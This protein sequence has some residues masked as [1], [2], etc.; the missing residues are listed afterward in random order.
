MLKKIVVY[1]FLTVL[2]TFHARA[3]TPVYD[4]AV[5]LGFDCQVAWQLEANNMRKF[6]YPFDWVHTHF[7]SLINFIVNKGANFLDADKIAVIGPYP[8]DPSRLHV[9]DVVYG[10]ISYHDFRANPPFENY[11]EV[12]AKYDRRIKRFFDL[13]N[14][15]KKV[16]F[17]R[18]GLT[19]PQ[20][21]FL[22]GLLH[23]LYPTL[24]YT[25]LAVNDDPEYLADWGLERVRNFYIQQTLGMWKGDS[26]R[27]KEILSAFSLSP[28]IKGISDDEREGIW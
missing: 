19:R 15:N 23:F 18:Y 8:G 17:V 22:D 20:V 10:I 12:K 16:L 1:V 24:S 26:A 7:D 13:L 6:A 25:I 27:W 9:I 3:K 14:S 2:V 21:E 28:K 11:W 5:S 4:E